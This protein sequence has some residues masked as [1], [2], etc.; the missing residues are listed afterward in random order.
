MILPNF[1][2]LLLPVLFIYFV[3]N[4][5][6][7]SAIHLI[8][9][10]ILAYL[11]FPLILKIEKKKISR[12]V[13]TIGIFL[14]LFTL[15]LLGLSWA[16][17][18]IYQGTVEF[19]KE[20]PQNVRIVIQK[21]E[22]I[23]SAR[24]IEIQFDKAQLIENVRNLSS[25]I[26]M[27]TFG[28]VTSFITNSFS[29]LGSFISGIINLFL[30]PI[31]FYFIIV[32]Y[33]EISKQMNSLVPRSMRRALSNYF[34]RINEIFGGFF[35]GQF[36]VCLVQAIFYG[37]G[38]SLIGLKHGLIIG[39]I[40]GLLCFIPYV[41]FTLGAGAALVVALANFEGP[42]PLIGV[43]AVFIIG[44]VVEGLYLTPK[45]VGGKVGLNPLLALLSLLIGSSVGGLLGMFLAIPLG[46]VMVLTI[47][48][49]VKSYKKST[50]YLRK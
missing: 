16:L 43:G 9:S 22:G 7:N 50:F 18:K 21:L 40:T 36:T 17:P 19:I 13:A 26:S 30:F 49:F 33:E 27:E 46:A 45:F 39:F 47:K 20:L 3:L 48:L 8:L 35:R 41:G 10:F 2:Y 38:L 44:Q 32:N 25:K 11:T 5:L 29:G 1:A 15:I 37:V 6:G 31:F 42:G 23:L 34:Q 4:A 24:G 12:Q 14:I 28:K